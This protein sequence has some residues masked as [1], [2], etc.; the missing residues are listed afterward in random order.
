MK[1]SVIDL[2]IIPLKHKRKIILI[3]IIVAVVAVAFVVVSKKLPAEISYLP[4]VYT[5]EAKIFLPAQDEKVNT[6]QIQGLTD[7][8]GLRVEKGVRPEQII[9]NILKTNTVVDGVIE[10]YVF[11]N[12]PEL[13]K[14]L[15]LGEINR[16][17]LRAQI[18]D[19]AHFS[20]DS[21]T[22]FI[23]IGYTDINPWFARG[24]VDTFLEMS[25]KVTFNFALTHTT[26]KKRFIE[27]RISE[28]K[29]KLDKSK[30]DY[31]NFQQTYGMISPEYE[32][33]QIGDTIAKLRTQLIEKEAVLAGYQRIHHSDSDEIKQVEFEVNNLRTRIKKLT[34]G[35]KTKNGQMIISKSTI[36][37]LSLEFEQ[38]KRT[39]NN[40]ESIYSSLLNE[41]E[42]AQIQEQ[43]E[44][45]I[46]QVL[47][48]PEVPTKK[49][50]PSRAMLLVRIMVVSLMLTIGFP[51]GR[52]VL[53]Q[54]L[55]Q[56]SD[57]KA[58]VSLLVDNL[59]F[60]KRA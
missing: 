1:L 14:Q 2:L 23:F 12:R 27:G 8:F 60:K 39:V 19:S 59:S 49:S 13:K 35:G 18:L 25:N 22:G 10:N 55:A 37:E 16:E 40:L 47:D 32:A 48:P 20:N 50:G 38:L 43:S 3:N 52:G 31:I 45:P 15:D 44:G 53:D 41:L 46:I 5:S 33:Q 7:N 57:L 42:I 51:V 36:S 11:V 58:K 6:S 54:V 21:E 56:N 34:T 29:D 4:N 28:I 24:M 26:L 30:Q 17:D 9:I